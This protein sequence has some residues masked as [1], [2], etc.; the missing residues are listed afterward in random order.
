MKEPE[1]EQMLDRLN[2]VRDRYEAWWTHQNNDALYYIIFPDGDYAELEPYKKDWMSPQIVSNW[3]NWRQEFLFGH[4]VELAVNTGEDHY[5]EDALDYLE[6]YAEITGHEAE[7]FSFLLPTLGPSCLAALM[8]GQTRF[9]GS[10][11]W[12]E[13]ETPMDWDAIQ[14]ITVDSTTKYAEAA[15][16]YTQRLVD[17]LQSR[18]VIATP[19]LGNGLDVLS[20]LRHPQNLLL[21]TYDCPETI[22][23][24][25]DT[26]HKLWQRY[27][28]A[29]SDIIDP[30]NHGC[31]VETM[32]WLSAEPTHISY[33]DFSAMI[34]PGMFRDLVKPMVQKECDQ[35]NGRVIFHL[36]GPG[37]IPHV[38]ELCS[39][40][41]LHAI[42]WVP[43]AGNEGCLSEKHDGL[44]RQIIDGGKRI[45]IGA[46]AGS[47]DELK[48]LFSRF[49]AEEFIVGT[50]CASRAAAQ[51]F[52]REMR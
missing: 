43:G 31:Y 1:R 27:H 7:G 24:V 18:Y 19:D 3:T 17:R 36:D 13:H 2:D 35:F 50:V 14:E 34:S 5:V 20:P 37:E 15:L 45:C 44:Y 38:P 51:D 16:K 9:T 46:S 10:T 12:L 47:C 41:N 11:I 42:Q 29:F 21:D 6:K 39:V 25:L 32:R 33:C 23:T 52:I 48:R 30:G 26:V 4:A 8:T 40:D 22:T 49:P 28:K